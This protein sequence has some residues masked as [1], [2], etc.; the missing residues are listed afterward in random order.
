VNWTECPG[1]KEELEAL[2]RKR[3]KAKVKKEGKRS[4]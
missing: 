3:S 4:E 2:E 1:R